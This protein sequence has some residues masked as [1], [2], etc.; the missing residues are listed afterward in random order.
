MQL[1]HGLLCGGSSSTHSSEICRARG[2]SAPAEP[3]GEEVEDILHAALAVA[4]V[5]TGRG[6]AEPSVQEVENILDRHR[7]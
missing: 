2:E 7:A 3:C 1:S 4:V 6:S 5:I